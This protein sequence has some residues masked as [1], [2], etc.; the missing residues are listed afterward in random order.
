MFKKGKVSINIRGV[1]LYV[2]PVIAEELRLLRLRNNELERCVSDLKMELEAVKPI[3]E[4]PNLKPA[5]SEHCRNCEFVVRSPWNG[6]IL[7]C[8]KGVICDDFKERD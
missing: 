2:D 5:F 4:N 8:R 3:L 7:R 6:D 1:N